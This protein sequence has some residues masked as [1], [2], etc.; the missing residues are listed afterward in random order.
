MRRFARAVVLALV[1]GSAVVA[2][3]T[4]AA[5]DPVVQLPLTNLADIEVD[6][7]HGYV[8][9]TG[10]WGNDLL[11]VRDLNGAAVTTITDLDDPTQMAFAPDGNT[12]YVSVAD[13]I[14]AIDPV[15]LT[16]TARYATGANSCPDHLATAGTKIWFHYG[17][18]AN[19]GKLG[20][21]ELGGEEPVV[22]LNA[23]TYSAS[24]KDLLVTPD[25]TRMIVSG[26]VLI[27]IDGTTLTVLDDRSEEIEYQ[28]VGGAALTPDAATMLTV[29]ENDV[30]RR[31]TVADFAEAGSFGTV[32]E[33]DGVPNGIA[34]SATGLV[35]RSVRRIGEGQVDAEVY[36]AD[37]TL[38]R[39]HLRGHQQ[40]VL[41][42]GIAITPDGSRLYLVH[43]AQDYST[44]LRV[45]ANPAKQVSTITLAK[46]ASAKINV[47]H[48]VTGTLKAAVQPPAGTVLRVKRVSKYGTTGLPNVTTAANGAF[49]FTGKVGRR[50]SYTYTVTYDGDSTRL[51]A[52]RPV[53][54]TVTGL[55]PSLSIA[56]N[57]STYAYRAVATATA[58]LGTTSSNRVVT[59]RRQRWGQETMATLKSGAVNSSG[60]LSGTA[61]VEWRTV[62]TAT[63][64]GDDVYEPRTVSKV[65][66]VQAGVRQS[67]SGYY[68]T[69]GSYRLYRTSVAPKLAVTIA[70]M[71][72]YACATYTAQ[73]YYSGAWRTVA[74]NA[75]A[76]LDGT[77]KVTVTFGSARTA[78]YLYRVRAGWPGDTY[79]AATQGAWQY[80][81]FTY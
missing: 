47:T 21:V 42:N 43:G 8:F 57:K 35:A 10:G 71:R 67:L 37:G 27:G 76:Q 52:T 30:I 6:A 55:T 4:A 22:A 74:T 66:A 68:G 26:T 24:I 73:R 11:V 49:S 78:G 56:T 25:G 41:R 14:V 12:L 75:C 69:S 31:V 62:F 38:L 54:L 9:V 33:W 81:R 29:S 39:E 59:I 61:T 65:V 77:S 44:F 58:H 63:F 79:N 80:L 64:A 48:I 51:P 7:A 19:N 72:Q 3:G 18:C 36:A 20:L 16:E 46:P 53:V 1:L 45:I 50:G 34:V 5:A 13:A 28:Y 70:P 23:L 60:N 2:P 32:H 40:T 17:T 15:T